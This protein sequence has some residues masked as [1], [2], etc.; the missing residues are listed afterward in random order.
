MRIRSRLLLL[1]SAVLVPALLV[2]VIGVAYIYSEEQ[3]SNRA[4]AV[5]TARALARAVERDMARRESILR[6]LAAAPTLHNG[7]L[8]RF[9]AYALAVANE[10]GAAIILS[11]LEG[12][13]ILNTRLPFGTALP[14]MR[15]SARRAHAWATRSRSSATSTCRPPA[16][17]P[18]ALRCSTRCGAT[19]RWCSS[20]PSLRSRRRSRIC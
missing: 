14:P 12:R 16:W 1:V 19:A 3:E 13:Q 5:E 4:T 10:S 18:I 2:S 17:A 15:S 8:Q 6:T 9:Y 20:S 11:D 7:E